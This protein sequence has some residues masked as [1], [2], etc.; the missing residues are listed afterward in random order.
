LRASP[1]L[2]LGRA[3]EDVKD[4]A[5]FALRRLVGGV[6]MTVPGGRAQYPEKHCSTPMT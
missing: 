5:A 6:T 4:G 3:E 2:T 1:A